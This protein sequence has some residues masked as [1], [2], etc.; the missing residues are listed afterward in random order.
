MFGRYRRVTS[1]PKPCTVLVLAPIFVECLFSI[2]GRY[3]PKES[4]LMIS[5]GPT[6]L[7]RSEFLT[8]ASL[9]IVQLYTVGFHTVSFPKSMLNIFNCF[10]LGFILVKFD[11][12][13]FT[14]IY[15][16]LQSETVIC[17]GYLLEVK[18][19]SFWRL[20]LGVDFYIFKIQP[21]VLKDN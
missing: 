20:G 6:A 17:I 19:G 21:L 10:T 14:W 4:F 1:Y 9:Q 8:C 16:D 12:Q 13:G 15:Q 5:V 3:R 11:F 7:Q 2:I 18:L